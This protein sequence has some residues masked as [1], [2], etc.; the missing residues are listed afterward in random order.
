MFGAHR[1]RPQEPIFLHS[2]LLRH[3]GY[4]QGLGFHSEA[5]G[6]IFFERSASYIPPNLPD[7]IESTKKGGRE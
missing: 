1:M 7:L 5:L 2:M 3:V 6:M 4:K